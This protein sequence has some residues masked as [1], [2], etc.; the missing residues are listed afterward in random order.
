MASERRQPAVDSLAQVSASQEPLNGGSR[1]DDVERFVG[2][3][4]PQLRVDS[5]PP[6]C[7]AR[8]ALAPALRAI[9]P[10]GSHT[11]PWSPPGAPR[12]AASKPRLPVPANRSRQRAPSTREPSQLNSVSL[13]RSGVGRR[14]STGGNRSRRRR[15]VPLMI[16]TL[17]GLELGMQMR[18]LGG[19]R[20]T[21]TTHR[22]T[23]AT[24]VTSEVSA[25]HGRISCAS[26]NAHRPPRQALPD[27][28]LIRGKKNSGPDSGD[29]SKA[30]PATDPPGDSPTAQ[31]PE[32][33]AASPAAPTSLFGRL[34]SAL[35]RT[36]RCARATRNQ[37]VLGANPPR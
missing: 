28:F 5:P 24:G 23:V 25:N 36:P 7:E 10:G 21:G 37:S 8:P 3:G 13:T 27:M 2:A 26:R 12:E 11:R 30:N 32:P 17:C 18:K 33:Q 14:P 20:G 15:H 1:K 9:S 35:H 6:R 31:N 29:A 34:K 22:R 19:L 16:R 4:Q